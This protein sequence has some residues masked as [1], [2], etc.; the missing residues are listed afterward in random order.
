MAS[1][2]E[3]KRVLAVLKG[4]PHDGLVLSVA[5]DAD[6]E[7]VPVTALAGLDEGDAYEKRG[8]RKKVTKAHGADAWDHDLAGVYEYRFKAGS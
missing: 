8:A 6:G 3:I 1:G 4:G 2:Y 7:P 5:L